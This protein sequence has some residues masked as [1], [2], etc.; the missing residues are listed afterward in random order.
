MKIGLIDNDLISR[1]KH[2]FPNLAIMKMSSFY[3]N[4]GFNVKLIGFNEINPNTL[5]SHDFNEIFVSKAFTD[6]FTPDYIFKLSNI[7]IGGTGFYFD[8]ALPLDYEIE[9]SKPDYSIYNNVLHLVGKREFYTNYSIG[10]TTR[11]CFRHCPFCVNVGS[12]KVELHSPIDEFYDSN[13][14]KLAMLDDNVLGL[15][16]KELYKIFDR[17]GEI[18]KPFQY[19]QAMDIRLLTEERIKFLFNLKYDGEYYFAFDLW[20]YKDLIERKMNLFHDL[21]MKIKAKQK[22]YYIHTKIYLFTG[23]DVNNKYDE[24]FWV[25]D[26][27]ILFKR[28]EI[29]FKYKMCP[30]IMRYEKVYTSPFYKIYI[31]LTQWCNSPAFYTKA[32]FRQFIETSKLCTNETKSFF[33]KQRHLWKYLELKL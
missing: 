19:R 6:S 33:D 18:N 14:P 23:L 10:F 12:S 5:F 21:Y 2:N 30:Y 26:I 11:G 24:K 15:P 1:D 20:E 13:K 32:T 29:C 22:T 8:K 7:K 27:E 17:L 9:H 4:K 3:K 28:I 31:N 16:N 25:N